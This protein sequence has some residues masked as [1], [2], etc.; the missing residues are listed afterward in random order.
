MTTF[1]HASRTPLKPGTKI[2]PF[3]YS[4]HDAKNREQEEIFEKVRKEH[5][6]HKPPRIGSV[7]VCPELDGFCSGKYDRKYVYEVEVKGGPLHWADAENW[8]EAVF[9]GE[10]ERW[11]HQYWKKETSPQSFHMFKEVIVGGGDVTVKRAVTESQVEYIDRLLS[12]QVTSGKL[13]NESSDLLT[14]NWSAIRRLLDVRSPLFHA[15]TGPRIAMILRDGY[16]KSSEPRDGQSRPQVGI[17]TA[18][19]LQ[20]LL[21][22]EFGNAVLVLDKDTMKQKYRIEPYQYWGNSTNSDWQD[23]QEERVMTDKLS[24]KHIR[25][26]I[27]AGRAPAKFE[28]KHMASTWGFPIIYKDKNEKWQRYEGVSLQD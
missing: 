16:M 9:R 6:P 22:G 14:E 2:R 8:T 3:D 25:G 5:F 1:Y 18:R 28:L 21:G 7:F 27:F 10:A 24:V 4:R 11:A 12:Y 19:T 23:E 20:P 17:S 15:T 26:I 13:V